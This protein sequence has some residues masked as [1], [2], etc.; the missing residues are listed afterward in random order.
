MG[1]KDR[2]RCAPGLSKGVAIAWLGVLASKKQSGK[3]KRICA[4]FLH[5]GFLCGQF[6]REQRT[7]GKFNE[8]KALG[9]CARHSN[10]SR[11]TKGRAT[12]AANLVLL[13][14]DM[15][16]GRSSC[17]GWQCAILTVCEALWQSGAA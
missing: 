8:N 6:D 1:K 12:R 17:A 16:L 11:E 15:A 13:G 9:K 5:G 10:V 14:I 4:S 2:R 3:K 7:E